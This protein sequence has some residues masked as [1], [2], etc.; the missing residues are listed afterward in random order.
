MRCPKCG[1][2]NPLMAQFCGFCGA[3]LSG[4]TVPGAPSTTPSA[5]APAYPPPLP[6]FLLEMPSPWQERYAVA[7]SLI[8]TGSSLR[9]F[10]AILGGGFSLL[11]MISVSQIA[12]ALRF[13]IGSAAGGV[14]FWLVLVSLV[15]GGVIGV[16]LYALGTFVRA[17]GFQLA[18]LLNLEVRSVPDES[19]PADQKEQILKAAARLGQA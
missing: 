15:W 2:E 5:M 17:S 19:L 18:T 4:A 7:Y 3:P 9:I 10:G 1:Q 6:A 14:I 13:L 12:D 11:M 16:G 8:R